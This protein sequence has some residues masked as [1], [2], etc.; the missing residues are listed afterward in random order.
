MDP[1]HGLS[2]ACLTGVSMLTA[3]G[4][5]CA[6]A[7]TP[8]AAAGRA[9]RIVAQQWASSKIDYAET[10]SLAA[11]KMKDGSVQVFATAKG[12]DR[13]DIYDASTGK[14]LRH[15]GGKGTAVGQ[16]KYPNGIVVV[17]F[18][19]AAAAS[20]RGD[21]APRNARTASSSQ[22]ST[23]PAMQRSSQPNG[24][25]TEQ[26]TGRASSQPAETPIEPERFVLVV[27][28]DN[29]RVQV[30][31]PDGPTPV[32]TFGERDLKR[33]YG[34]AVSYSGGDVHLYV[35]D[36]DVSPDYVVHQYKLAL[37]GD[38][39]VAEHVRFF[40][41]TEGHGLIQEAESVCVDDRLGR[42]LLCDEKSQDVKVYT[43][44]GEFT[45]KTF[46]KGL[47]QGDPE[48]IQICDSPGGGF[49]VLTDQQSGITIWRLFDREQYQHLGSFTGMPTVANTDGICIYASPLAGFPAGA[50]FAVHD[51]TEI[52]AYALGD[53][54]RLSDAARSDP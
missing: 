4:V 18:S 32:S 43:T 11:C 24:Q 33:P 25:G 44:A 34:A 6:R 15:F 10:D 8:D 47:V 23:Q 12:G 5:V 20:A 19:R 9:T 26:P 49:V 40:G 28:R 45:G 29:A 13:L 46:A 16:F 30:L 22:P 35:T 37:Q 39:F 17:E 21:D 53:V 31:R 48:G 36:T 27:E 1:R 42:V 38:R 54:I 52:R 41:E 51:D 14:F 7:Q 50:L 3:V 2:R